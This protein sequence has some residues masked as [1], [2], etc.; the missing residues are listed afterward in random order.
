MGSSVVTRE[1]RGTREF[2]LTFCISLLVVE[3][4]WR[5]CST[6]HLTFRRQKRDEVTFGGVFGR[7][8]LPI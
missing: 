2:L 1:T 3:E 4:T 7:D 6:G 5:I 8:L